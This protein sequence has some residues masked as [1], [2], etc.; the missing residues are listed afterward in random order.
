MKRNTVAT[1]FLKIMIRITIIVMTI[2]I[3]DNND[4]NEGDIQRGLVLNISLVT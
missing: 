1:K 3:G 2:L 4:N